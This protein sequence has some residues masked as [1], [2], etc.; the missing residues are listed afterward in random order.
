MFYWLFTLS[1]KITKFYD[2]GI[3]VVHNCFTQSKDTLTRSIRAH[4]LRTCDFP[5]KIILCFFLMIS[6][7][8]MR[9]LNLLIFFIAIV[10]T[11]LYELIVCFAF[12][13]TNYSLIIVDVISPLYYCLLF[14]KFVLNPPFGFLV[15]AYSW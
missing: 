12:R 14:L 1:I 4:G 6:N 11:Y 15:H 13:I 3:R 5:L 2:L 10:L 7:L 8:L 9:E